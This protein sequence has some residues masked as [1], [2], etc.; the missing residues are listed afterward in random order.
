L[1]LQQFRNKNVNSHV[2]A[3]V[4][5]IKKQADKDL[6]ATVG[7]CPCAFC[8][9]KDHELCCCT[10]WQTPA[11]ETKLRF[12]KILTGKL[13]KTLCTKSQSNLGDKQRKLCRYWCAM[14]VIRPS[15]SSFTSAKVYTVRTCLNL[16]DSDLESINQAKNEVLHYDEV[17]LTDARRRVNDDQEI[18]EGRTNCEM[19]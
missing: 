4:G 14:L 18:E 5:T 2:A 11:G 19:H 12:S 3:S 6:L 17:G 9:A 7:F 1:Q 8:T 13:F 16:A 15:T 10:A